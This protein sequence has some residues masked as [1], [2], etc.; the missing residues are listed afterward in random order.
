MRP[1]IILLC[2]LAVPLSAAQR[3]FLTAAE[4]DQLREEQEPN[5]R[6]VLYVGF[7]KQRVSYLQQ[8]VAKEKA[9]RATLIHDVLDEYT[10]IIDA[11]DT[12]TDDAIRRKLP[13]DI[14]IKAVVD[15][16]KGILP[17]LLKI[18]D[19]P[20]KDASLYKFVLEQATLAT[21]DSLELAQA[22]MSS[23]ATDINARDAKERADREAA[24]RTEEVQEK[25]EAEK[26]EAEQK[27]KAPTLRRPGEVAAP[28]P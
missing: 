18:S 2:L 24:T 1:W 26:K 4:V 11:I 27:K 10:K 22:D 25:R 19:S 3:D 16:E 21:E 9:G 6:L 15:A 28:K 23:R 17:V 13:L 7:A 8:L 14:G 20:P 12:V 5:Q